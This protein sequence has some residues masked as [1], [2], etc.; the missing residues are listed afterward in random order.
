MWSFAS[1]INSGTLPYQLI[2]GRMRMLCWKFNL[3][4][5]TCDFH[6]VKAKNTE[7]LQYNDVGTHNFEAKNIYPK[8]WV[9]NKPKMIL[10]V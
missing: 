10:L 8:Q 7:V 9:Q 5:I 4:P 1:Q 6:Y 3:I 2:I